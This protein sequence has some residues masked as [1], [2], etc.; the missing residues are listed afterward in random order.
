MN[1]GVL[2]II[3]IGIAVPDT[4]HTE[5]RAADKPIIVHIIGSTCFAEHVNRKFLHDTG[6]RTVRRLCRAVQQLIHDSGVIRSHDLLSL[7][8]AVI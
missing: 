7:L 6:S 1:G 4:G 8:F 2:Q 3:R 5:W